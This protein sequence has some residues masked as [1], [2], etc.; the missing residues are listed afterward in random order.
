METMEKPVINGFHTFT[1]DQRSDA[2]EELDEIISDLKNYI[3]FELG[4]SGVNVARPVDVLDHRPDIIRA[5][6]VEAGERYL[7]NV[8]I[9]PLL[10]EYLVY[11]GFSCPMDTPFD[12]MMDDAETQDELEEWAARAMLWSVPLWDAVDD[13]LKDFLESLRMFGRGVVEEYRKGWFLS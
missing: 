12:G 9:P 10:T 7:E 13:V 11:G 1:G 5:W 2:G 3:Y 4:Y 6:A 8:Y